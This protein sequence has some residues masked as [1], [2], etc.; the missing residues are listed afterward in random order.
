VSL[1]LIATDISFPTIKQAKT[2]LLDEIFSGFGRTQYL[3]GKHNWEQTNVSPWCMLLAAYERPFE[4]RPWQSRRKSAGKPMKSRTIVLAALLVAT[5]AMTASGQS[6]VIDWYKISSGGGTVSAGAYSLSGT[7]GQPDAGNP[8]TGGGYT[9]VGGFWSP[10]ILVQTPGVPTLT[11]SLTPTNTT[12]IFWAWPSTG[13]SLQEN[14]NLGS[15]NW[16]AAS[17]VTA[18]DSMNN[19][20]LVSPPTGNRF[21]RLIRP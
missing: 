5:G 2:S 1:L 18:H 4:H 21:Y 14:S 10:V 16:A 19:F 6:Y 17:E 13:W 20:I 11:I 9:I 8:I 3:M 7:I 15:T 12:A